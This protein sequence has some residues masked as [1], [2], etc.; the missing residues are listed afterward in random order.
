MKDQR[1]D[2]GQG[3]M[4]YR[5]RWEAGG[6]LASALAAYQGR[7]PVVLGIPR[8]GVPVAAEVARR[9]GGDLDIVVARKLG[10]PMH[11]EL[12]IGAVTADGGRFLND[13]IVGAL[14]VDPAY[15]E[16][17]TREQMREAQRRE[18]RFREARP[19]IELKDRPV[20]LVDDGLATGATMIAAVRAVRA[21]HP[22]WLVVGVPVGSAESCAALA[23]EADEVVCPMRPEPFH[24]IGLHYE[25]FEPV[26]DA[27]VVSLLSDAAL[28]RS[29]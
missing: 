7:H 18:A 17:V 24:P 29:P 26:Q 3:A 2:V 13:E 5:D 9:L 25:H 11:P 10:A 6:R 21:R 27:E 20:I 15:V 14:G 16:Q 1:F 22:A 8:G 4:P 19:V 23:T 12:A 28:L